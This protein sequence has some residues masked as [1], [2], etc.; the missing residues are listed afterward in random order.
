MSPM[1]W[2]VMSQVTCKATSLLFWSNCFISARNML[3]DIPCVP[4]AREYG[5]H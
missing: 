4:G 3:H 2:E 5:N 1:T